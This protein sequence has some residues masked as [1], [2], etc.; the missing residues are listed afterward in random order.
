[1]W[2]QMQ[3]QVVVVVLGITA[4]STMLLYADRYHPHRSSYLPT[5]LLENLG[6]S[7]F[8]RPPTYMHDIFNK[9]LGVNYALLLVPYLR[10]F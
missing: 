10:A 4:L 8:S 7:A 3:R 2:Q 9:T 5:Y 6:S 1:M